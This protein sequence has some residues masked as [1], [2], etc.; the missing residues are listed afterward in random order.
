M[1]GLARPDDAAAAIGKPIPILDDWV[2]HDALLA[3]PAPPPLLIVTLAAGHDWK[4]PPAALTAAGHEAAR[5][6]P[7]IARRIARRLLD[8]SLERTKTDAIDARGLARLACEQRPPVCMTCS[9]RRCASCSSAATACARIST[10]SCAN[11]T[12]RQGFAGPN[13]PATSA[14]WTA[15][16]RPP[17][18]RIPQRLPPLTAEPRRVA[19]RRIGG[20]HLVGPEQAQS[21]LVEVMSHAAGQHCRPAETLQAPHIRQVL[22]TSRRRLA[23]TEPGI[24]N[25]PDTHVLGRLVTSIEGI[26]PQTTARTIAVAGDPAQSRG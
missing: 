18:Q 24:E 1:R 6:N 17:A 10:T 20:R 12:A 7:L 5:G 8:A 14:R 4:R 26:G 15:A 3:V 22:N 23:Q 9:P 13:S 19:W 21:P 2:D 11:G 25:L 16:S